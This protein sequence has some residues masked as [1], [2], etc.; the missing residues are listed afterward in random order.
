MAKANGNTHLT[1]E[2]RKIIETG[3]RNGS[4]KTAI[5]DTLGK[6]NSTIG[7]EIK[8]H[9]VLS[10]K[11]HMPLECKAYRKCIHGR[12][13]TPDC[14]GY[15]PFTC[16]RRDRSPGA[17]NGCGKWSKCRF[18]KF[19]YD[20]EKAHSAYR[21]TL[22]DAR[23]GVN[24]TA[25]EARK[26]AETVAPLL[27]QGLSPY[28]ILQASPELKICEKTLYNYIED[29]ILHE[30]GGIAAIDLRRKVGRKLPKEK[31]SKL[32]KR[33]DRRFL[34]GRC[35]KDYLAYKDEHPDSSVVE[36]DTVYNN[37]STGPFIQ[38]FKFRCCGAV[39]AIIH[40][41]KTAAEMT[42]GVLLLESVLGR[43]VFEKYVQILLTDRGTEFSSPEPM[44]IRD[45]GTTRTRVFYCDPMQSGQ[46]GSL[47]NSHELLRYVCPKGVDLKELGLT[48]QEALNEVI[49]NVDS[50]P[51]ESFGGRC[52]LE[53]AEF[54]YA[55]L[56]RALSS[57]GIS[58]VNKDEIVLKPYLLKKFRNST[59]DS[60]K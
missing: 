34:I 18:N 1:L 28:A 27:G 49:R 23:E 5:S 19:T 6:D 16:P 38:T 50:Y 26:I 9:R 57:Y 51:V 11:C 13:C 10:H 21:Y 29:G 24:L 42:A 59:Y 53:V 40:W 12:Y 22:V 15:V 2:E 52:P 46:K 54:M 43:D 37:E 56:H 25:S 39:F 60:K 17:C 3:I 8:L 44:E 45:D 35:Y 41:E 20:A 4:T 7:K 58:R 33:H 48:G 30:V 47:E 31:R 14:P 32:K 55:D 36:M